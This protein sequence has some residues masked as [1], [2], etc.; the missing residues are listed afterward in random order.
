MSAYRINFNKAKFM[1]FMIKEE[2][3]F[4]KYMEIWEKLSN[5]IKKLKF[6]VNLC[7]F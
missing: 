5:V 1:Y 3:V 6:I 2:K 7:I 4:D